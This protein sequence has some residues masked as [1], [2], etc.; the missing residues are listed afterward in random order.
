MQIRNG[1][2]LIEGLVSVNVLG[3][4]NDVQILV[5]ALSFYK[6]LAPSLFV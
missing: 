5:S 3:K 4:G 1:S 6:L 2:V